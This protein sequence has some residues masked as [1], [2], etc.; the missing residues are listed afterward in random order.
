MNIAKYDK[1][2]MKRRCKFLHGQLTKNSHVVKSFLL[3][4]LLELI[5][6]V[7][8]Q[9]TAISEFYTNHDTFQTH[10]SK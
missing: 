2:L 7:A 6:S 9:R 10:T 4:V 5:K 3:L 1:P 8:S